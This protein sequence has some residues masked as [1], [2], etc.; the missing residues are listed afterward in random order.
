ML[1]RLPF[2][3]RHRHATP[4][5]TSPAPR[6]AASR[7][8]GE[9]L[10]AR[11]LF[12]A[13]RQLPEF[14][15]HTLGPADDKSVFVPLGFAGPVNAFGDS[16]DGVYVNNNGNVTFGGPFSSFRPGPL[17]NLTRPMLAPFFADVDTLFGGSPVTYGSTTI[18]G[19]A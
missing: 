19:H 11:V 9:R 4:A 15:A 12:S 16:F 17:A 10:E 1:P 8:A 6:P 13:I 7:A 14:L 3:R 5:P 2:A 18:D